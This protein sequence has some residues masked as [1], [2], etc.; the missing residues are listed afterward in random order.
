MDITKQIGNIASAINNQ[1][2]QTNY[3]TVIQELQGLVTVLR[4]DKTYIEDIVDF[5]Q[6]VSFCTSE[7]ELMDAI[8]VF[9]TTINWG[10]YKITKTKHEYYTLGEVIRLQLQQYYSDWTLDETT[11]NRIKLLEKPF[12]KL[13]NK[14]E[15]NYYAK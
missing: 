8:G 10:D 14:L 3:N 4:S 1:Y 2:P 13:F 7:D 11:K 6:Q 5:L 15:R 12:K 9:V